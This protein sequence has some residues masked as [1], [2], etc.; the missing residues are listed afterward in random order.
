MSQTTLGDFGSFESERVKNKGNEIILPSSLT[1]SKKNRILNKSNTTMPDSEYQ[2]LYHKITYL[3]PRALLKIYYGQHKKGSEIA[4]LVIEG[5]HEDRR[6][7]KQKNID[8]LDYDDLK[9]NWYLLYKLAIIHRDQQIGKETD[10]EPV[11]ELK[12]SDE[13]GKNNVV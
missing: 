5:Y 9:G 12:D 10:F 13:S 4:Q 8:D 6:K 2:K 1:T 3:D 7:R 11:E